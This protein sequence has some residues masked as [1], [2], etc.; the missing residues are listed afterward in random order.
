MP[1]LRG[2][3]LF[4]GKERPFLPRSQISLNM[5]RKLALMLSGVTVLL[6][7]GFAMVQS[8]TIDRQKTTIRQQKSEIR[9]KSQELYAAYRE[10]ERLEATL[11]LLRDSLH[12]LQSTIASLELTIKTQKETIRKLR[13]RVEAQQARLDELKAEIARLSRENGDYA[14]RIRRLEEQKKLIRLEMEQTLNQQDEA[15]NRI[16]LFE[17]RQTQTLER[18]HNTRRLNDLLHN[19]TVRFDRVRLRKKKHGGDIHELKYNRANWKY[20]ILEFFLE[21]P[22]R[23]LLLDEEFLVQIF[24]LDTG[25]VLPV[26]ERNPA[27]PESALDNRGYRFLYDG[28]LVEVAYFN[29]QK[30]KSQNYEVRIFLLRDGMAYPLKNGQL[31]IVKDGKVV[32]K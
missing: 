28:N 22:N 16:Q 32:E 1:L 29:S 11:Q 10:N 17:T 7:T 23:Q 30:K 9:Q 15:Q 14:E 3:P 31:Q 6:L 4:P 25:K 20:T 27:Y 21:H 19:T 18:Y 12:T 5:Q 8:T 2:R 26:N 24:D 13:Q